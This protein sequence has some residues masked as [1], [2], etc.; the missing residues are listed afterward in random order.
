M[1]DFL[2]DKRNFGSAELPKWDHQ[3][4]PNVGTLT[5][6]ERALYDDAAYPYNLLL[7]SLE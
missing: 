5:C 7:R 2:L 6:R 3:R 4:R 1:G